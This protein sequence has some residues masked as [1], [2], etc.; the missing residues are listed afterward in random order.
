MKKCPY[1]AEDI[2]DAAIVCRFCNRTLAGAP[3]RECWACKAPVSPADSVCHKCGERL[4]PSTR[5]A[6]GA[7]DVGVQASAGR[8]SSQATAPAV[9]IIA[10]VALVGFVWFSGVLTTR[11]TDSSGRMVLPTSIAAPPPVVTKAEYD[12]VGNGMTYEQVTAIIGAS[13]SELSRGDLAGFTSVMY[14]WTN[15]NSSGMNA[16]FQ[17]GKLV[18]KAQFGLP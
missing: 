4:N 8:T 11:S 18:Q 7:H 15:S 14:S 6:A 9:V 13:G 10:V 3:Q 2:Q 1:C 17:N 16:M 12:Q 5:T